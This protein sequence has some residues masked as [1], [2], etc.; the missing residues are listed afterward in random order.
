MKRFYKNVQ[1]GDGFRVLLDG[2]AV[3]TPGKAE[4]LIPWRPLAEA[5]AAEWAGQTEVVRPQGMPL[6]RLCTSVIDLFPGR[7]DDARGEIV[8][9]GAHDLLCYRAEEPSELRM[10]QD[11][12]WQPWVDWSADVLRAPLTV[13]TGISPVDQPESTL[14]RFENLV[15]GVDSW[16]LMGLHAAVKLTGSM[17]LGLALQRGELDPQAALAATLLDELFEIERWGL[18]KE[19]AGRHAGLRLELEAVAAFCR[20]VSD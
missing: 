19:Q 6:M 13:T 9:F 15:G 3:R 20:L 2:R 11:R 8:E 1:V 12:C 5:V 17:V 14:T 4:L 10:R 18:E 7:M 16:S